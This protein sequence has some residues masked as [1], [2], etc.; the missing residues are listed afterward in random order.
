[1]E[2]VEEDLLELLIHVMLQ[3][4]QLILEVEVEDLEMTDTEQQEVQVLLL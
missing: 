3:L 1:M 4:E 2:Q